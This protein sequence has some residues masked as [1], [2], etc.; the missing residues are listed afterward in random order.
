MG[1]WGASFYTP[2]PQP[3][4]DSVIGTVELKWFLSPP[5][6]PGATTATGAMSAV[7]L[8]F[9]RDFYDGILGTY[10]ERDR[11][12]VG[13][14]H[15]FAGKFLLLASGGVGPM[16]FPGFST[17]YT[18]A[19][20]GHVNSFTDARIDGSLF[21]E[22][23]FMDSFGVNATLLYDQEISNAQIPQAP[24]LADTSLAYQQIQAYLG[25]RWLM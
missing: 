8:G 17:A 10:Y 20:P 22:Y 19:K 12:Y 1:G 21:G 2:T 9:S 18:T 5:P 4:F 24:P 15:L 11:G 25:V 13:F 6:A 23:R 7:S 3:D 14:S 16:V